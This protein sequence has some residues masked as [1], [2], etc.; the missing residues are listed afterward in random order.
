MA[1]FVAIG[2][3]DRAGYDRTEP[4]IR[5]AAHERDAELRAEGALMRIAGNLSR[6]RNPDDC[7]LQTL[8]AAYMRSELPLAASG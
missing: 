2:Y 5:D 8:E 4:A 6:V 3:G 1:K 7:G